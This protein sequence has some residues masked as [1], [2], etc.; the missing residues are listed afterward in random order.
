M[1]NRC[2]EYAPTIGGNRGRVLTRWGWSRRNAACRCAVIDIGQHSRSLPCCRESHRLIAGE[3]LT[4]RAARC[5]TGSREGRVHLRQ[6]DHRLHTLIEHHCRRASG[7]GAELPRGGRSHGQVEVIDGSGRSADSARRPPVAL[8]SSLFGPGRVSLEE[9]DRSS[10]GE[11]IE[12]APP[13]VSATNSG[14]NAS[15]S[16]FICLLRGCHTEYSWYRRRS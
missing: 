6:R 14:T 10:S 4:R 11:P 3:A 7:I 1:L 13:G 9:A 2:I 5:H 12:S 8:R 16:C 15:F